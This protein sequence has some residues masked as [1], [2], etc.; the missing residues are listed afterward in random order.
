MNVFFNDKNISISAIDTSTT[1]KNKL[2]IVFKTLPKYIYFINGY[3]TNFEENKRQKKLKCFNSC[4][5][6]DVLSTLFY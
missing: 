5:A 3:P 4:N 2:A 6:C 1:V